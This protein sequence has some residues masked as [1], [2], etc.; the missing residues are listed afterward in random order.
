ML[1]LQPRPDLVLG[2]Q[3]VEGQAIPFGRQPFPASLLYSLRLGRRGV[4]R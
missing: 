2:A 1:N 3:S 4:K